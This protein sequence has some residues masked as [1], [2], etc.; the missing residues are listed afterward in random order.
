[1]L[2]KAVDVLPGRY[3]RKRCS[4]AVMEQAEWELLPRALAL[5]CT[6]ELDTADGPPR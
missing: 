4:S 6:E 1:M 5:F 2:Q 3:A